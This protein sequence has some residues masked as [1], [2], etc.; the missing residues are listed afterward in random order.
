MQN[1]FHLSQLSFSSVELH[2]PGGV[3]ALAL[4]LSVHVTA[5]SNT[6]FLHTLHILNYLDKRRGLALYVTIFLCGWVM[7][8]V[9]HWTELSAL[10]HKARIQS[11]QKSNAF[12][13]EMSIN[14]KKHPPGIN[15]VRNINRAHRKL[16]AL[17]LYSDFERYVVLFIVANT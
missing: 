17:V 9:L 7:M 11:I 3:K 16:L 1:A 10:I 5:L 15:S 8:N 2:Q 4:A 13:I 14:S 6:R 12:T